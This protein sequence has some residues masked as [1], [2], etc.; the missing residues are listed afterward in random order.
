MNSPTYTIEQAE[1]LRKSGQADLVDYAG[2]RALFLVTREAVYE[3][4]DHHYRFFSRVREPIRMPIPEE[5]IHAG[6]SRL[7]QVLNQRPV[8]RGGWSEG[9]I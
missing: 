3:R 6:D 4:V 1:E 8:L 9:S 2:E 7:V 5:D